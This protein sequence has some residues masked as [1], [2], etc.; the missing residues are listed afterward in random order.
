M[1]PKKILFFSFNFLPDQSA[2]SYRTA[3]LVKKIR[4]L[5]N[6]IDITILSSHPR[7][8]NQKHPQELKLIEKKKFGNYKEITIIRLWIPKYSSNF[9]SLVLAYSFYFFQSII[10]TLLIR[11]NLIVSTSAK[12]L[13]GF[14]S[15]FASKISGAKHCLDIRDTFVDNFFYFYRYEKRIFFH[16][17]F[18]IIE[19]LVIRW[20]DTLNFVSLGFRDLYFG[21]DNLLKKKSIDVTYFTQGINF[22]LKKEIQSQTYKKKDTKM[23]NIVYSGNIGEGQDILSLIKDIVH[24]KKT[25]QLMK[26]YNIRLIIYGAGSQLNDIKKFISENSSQIGM[27]NLN[28][29]IQIKGLIKKEN[30][31]KCYSNADVLLIHLAKYSS[32]ANVIPTKLFEYACTPLPILYASS[33]FTSKFI[34]KLKGTIPFQQSNGM[35]FIKK[36]I[37]AKN[38][39]LSSES[40][41]IF[42]NKFN[43]DIIYTDYARH[44]LNYLC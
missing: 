5:N 28:E 16:P 39:K 13:T 33:G 40:R 17:I 30:I 37:K 41:N 3:E 27:K 15:G 21:L 1:K 8:Y 4:E 43:S 6:E 19:N 32:L 10:S 23:L 29:F 35:S 38:T 14:A 7:R 22:K 44:I 34:S 36:A 26:D 18:L 11:P 2:G 24:N 31:Y 9:L 20:S 25:F 42:L 12:L